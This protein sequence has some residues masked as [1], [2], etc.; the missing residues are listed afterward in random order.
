MKVVGLGLK[1]VSEIVFGSCGRTEGVRR[2]ELNL[3]EI[4]VFQ[5]GGLGELW[6]PLRS[7]AGVQMEAG[8]VLV[9]RVQV[10]VKNKGLVW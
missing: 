10:V 4:R 5:G 2:G 9:N 7:E 3:Q 8:N 1:T 6:T